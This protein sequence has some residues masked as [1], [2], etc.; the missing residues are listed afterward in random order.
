MS[1]SL[2]FIISR[3]TGVILELNSS[4]E[5]FRLYD[6]VVLKVLFSYL[7]KL[8]LLVGFIVIQNI[9]ICINDSP[10]AN[11]WP[12]SLCNMILEYYRYHVSGYFYGTGNWLDDFGFLAPCLRFKVSLTPRWGA[13]I[14]TQTNKRWFKNYE[15]W[16]YPSARD[17]RIKWIQA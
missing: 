2:N 17:T 7:H 10:W 8:L 14:S 9:Y 12:I 15:I 5:T 13:T 4:T 11:F 1:S 3:L 16:L 6:L